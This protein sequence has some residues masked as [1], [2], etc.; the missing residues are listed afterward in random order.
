MNYAVEPPHDT[1]ISCVV[2]AITRRRLVVPA[3]FLL[4]M[5]KPLVGCMRELCLSFEPLIRMVVGEPLLPAVKEVL[6]SSERVE[7]L[8]QE[9]EL[10]RDGATQ[11]WAG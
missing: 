10:V 4:E 7:A 3:I 6:S 9:L 1:E 2:E 8:I 5:G 11:P